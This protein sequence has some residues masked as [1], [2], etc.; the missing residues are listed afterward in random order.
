MEEQAHTEVQEPEED[1]KALVE[2]GK[3]VQ[4]QEEEDR[5]ALVEEGRKA[6]VEEDKKALVEEDKKA[7]ELGLELGLELGP[8]CN[9]PGDNKASLKR[10]KSPIWC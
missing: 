1:R 7:Q 8:V 4:G 2:E 9:K 5:K 10:Q 6:L 3:K